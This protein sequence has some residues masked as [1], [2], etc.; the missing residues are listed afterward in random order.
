M[1]LNSAALSFTSG[2]GGSLVIFLLSVVS[3]AQDY[4]S[5]VGTWQRIELVQF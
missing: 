3:G 2:Y 4:Q 5:L 1:S